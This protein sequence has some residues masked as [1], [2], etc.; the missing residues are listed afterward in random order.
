MQVPHLC[1]LPDDREELDFKAI[2]R[3]FVQEPE[4]GAH[5]WSSSLSLF[6]GIE[7]TSH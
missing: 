1:T 5:N 6:Q 2:T 7:L 4:R 3:F